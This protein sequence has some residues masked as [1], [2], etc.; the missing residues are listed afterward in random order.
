MLLQ[1]IKRPSTLTECNVRL[2][3]LRDPTGLRMMPPY[4]TSA[5][6]DLDLWHPCPPKFRVSRPCPRTSCADLQQNWFMRF[7][8]IVFT[9]LT[10][11]R[12]GQ[13]K[14]HAFGHGGAI[15]KAGGHGPPVIWTQPPDFHHTSPKPLFG[16]NF[17]HMAPPMLLAS[18]ES[19]WGTA[20]IN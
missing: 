8:N 17:F 16:P 11:E 15:G 5:S 13:L 12:S 7:Q 10:D 6:C 3:K 1:K 14:K 4:L 18:L 9:S 20:E 2:S 19:V